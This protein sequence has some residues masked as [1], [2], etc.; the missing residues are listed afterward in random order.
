MADAEFHDGPLERME[1]MQLDE[2]G[3]DDAANF[4]TLQLSETESKILELYDRLEEIRLEISLLQT[5]G[6]VPEGRIPSTLFLHLFDNI[7]STH[8]SIRNCFG[9]R[10]SAC[11]GKAA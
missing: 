8:R 10:Y 4:P 2:L 9:E 5:Q 6:A 3:S 11:P 7:L 1:G